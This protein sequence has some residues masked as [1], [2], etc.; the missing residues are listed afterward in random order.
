MYGGIEVWK[1]TTDNDR[2]LDITK[3]WITKS[4]LVMTLQLLST[5]ILCRSTE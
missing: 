3:T 5:W 1:E 4:S 2:K